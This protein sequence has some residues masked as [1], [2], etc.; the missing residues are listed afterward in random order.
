MFQVTSSFS[1]GILLDIPKL[2]SWV[3]VTPGKSSVDLAQHPAVISA[4]FDS[5]SGRLGGLS[6]VADISAGA[7]F[8]SSIPLTDIGTLGIK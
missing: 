2:H 4:R 8:I 7:T 5:S 6:V 3:S 1:S